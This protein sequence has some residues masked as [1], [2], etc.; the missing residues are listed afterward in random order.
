MKK[1]LTTALVIASIMYAS[2]ASALGDNEKN[3]LSV[4]G[5]IFL[6][7]KV[8]KHYQRKNKENKDSHFEKEKR[9]VEHAYMEGVRRR[10]REELEAKK[11]AAYRCGYEGICE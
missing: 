5:G 6:V 8:A 9:E 10:E 3:F 2:S 11:L 4:L 7:D 1:L